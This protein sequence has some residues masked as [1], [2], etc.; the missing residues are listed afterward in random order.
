METLLLAYAAEDSQGVSRDVQL[1]L[2]KDDGLDLT[3]TV[4][5]QDKLSHFLRTCGLLLIGEE[6]VITG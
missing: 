5:L 2:D 1:L 6:L 4:T 3:N